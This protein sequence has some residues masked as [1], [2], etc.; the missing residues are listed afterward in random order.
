MNKAQGLTRHLSPLGA[1]AFAIGT[2]MGWGAL[3]VTATR[4][5]RRPVRRAACWGWRWAL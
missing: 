3:V 1:W 4:T 2:S 5:W